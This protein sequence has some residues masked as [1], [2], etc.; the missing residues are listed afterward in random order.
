VL[1][2]EVEKAHPRLHHLLLQL[3]DDGHLTDGRGRRVDFSRTVV[4]LTSN[5]G[6]GELRDASRRMGFAPEAGLS[7]EQLGEIT[8]RALEQQFAPELL[9]RLG[10]RVLFRDLEPEHAREVAGLL[11][12]D[13]ARRSR[14]RGITVAFR[15][16]VARWVAERGF[17]AESGARE[18]VHVVRREIETR[19]AELVLEGRAVRGRLVRVGLR[20]GEP[21]LV[22]ER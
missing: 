2:D 9:G 3:L 14:R 6:A 10:E 22:V 7:G 12:A 21:A 19:L 17:S 5:V 20:G 11:L 16:A 18:L 4:I 15:P 1:F 13:L 8:S